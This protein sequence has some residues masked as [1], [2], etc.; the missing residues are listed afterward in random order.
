MDGFANYRSAIPPPEFANTTLSRRQDAEHTAQRLSGAPE[1]LI[2]N[3]EGTDVLG[4]H[5]QLTHPT[6]RDVELAG[7]GRGGQAGDAR[8]AI[9]LD[10]SNPFIALRNQGFDFRQG[11]VAP[12][13]DRERLAVRA[14]GADTHA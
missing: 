8:L 7:D 13:L 10:I 11:K 2:A 3:R 1:Q 12:Q 9:I 6:H 14:H 5:C 4:T